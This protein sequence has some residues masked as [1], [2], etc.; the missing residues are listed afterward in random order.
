MKRRVVD[1]D[2]ALVLLE[3][4]LPLGAT[5]CLDA[6]NVEAQGPCKTHTHTHSGTEYDFTEVNIYDRLPVAEI[7]MHF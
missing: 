5:V 6:F 7:F 1:L 4:T 3:E 2:D